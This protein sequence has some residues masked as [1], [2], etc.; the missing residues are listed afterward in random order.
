VRWSLGLFVAAAQAAGLFGS[1]VSVRQFELPNR[2]ATAELTTGRW[3]V[4]RS[5]IRTADLTT[6]HR[7][8]A[9]GRR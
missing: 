5:V 6:D 4:V 3:S 2:H 8:V 7:P 9:R 1:S